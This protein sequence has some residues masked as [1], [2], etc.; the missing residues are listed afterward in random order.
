MTGLQNCCGKGPL[1]TI[2]D[3][4]A[5]AANLGALAAYPSACPARHEAVSWCAGHTVR[6]S[7]CSR[8][9]PTEQK[10]VRKSTMTQSLRVAAAAPICLLLSVRAATTIKVRWVKTGA[11]DSTVSRV[12]Q[13]CNA[14][15]NAALA[16]ERGI[17]QTSTRRS[18]EIGGSAARP[19]PN[20]NR[21]T[22]SRQAVVSCNRTRP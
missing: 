8:L 17:N 16:S 18:A 2:T 12:L 10:E 21:C 14:Q 3:F 20:S 6:R 1:P 5:R 19:R 13:D 9:P 4:A 15:A 22:S 11:G 7:R